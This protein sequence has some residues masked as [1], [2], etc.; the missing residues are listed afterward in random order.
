MNFNDAVNLIL[1]ETLSSCDKLKEFLT[2]RKAGAAK[3]EKMAR[4]KGGPS[5]LTAAHFKAK[6]VPYAKA[7]E[8]VEEDKMELCKENAMKC[9]KQLE[10]WDT[11][12]QMEFQ[13]I[14]GEFEASAESYLQS[15]K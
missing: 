2:K 8:H 9:L 4:K 15:K 13:K 5:L 14:S 10:K 3:I 11:L 12:T 7:I 1:E 6:A